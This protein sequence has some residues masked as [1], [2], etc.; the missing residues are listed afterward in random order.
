MY[1][2]E[3]PWPLFPP[4][5]FSRGNRDLELNDLTPFCPFVFE[6]L[7]EHDKPI[8]VAICRGT[9]DILNGERIK[10][11][12]V[13]AP[14][15]L[16]DQYR[17]DPL[18]SSI[19]VDSDLVPK[20]YFADITLNAIA[21]A[22]QGKKQANW[23]VNVHVGKMQ[24]SLFVNGPRHWEYSVLR[25]W[26]LSNA[27]AVEQIPMHYE[28]AF[29]GTWSEAGKVIPF[30]PNPVG[31]GFV[32]AKHLDRTQCIPAPQIEDPANPILELGK[33]YQPA[34]VGP[35]AKHWLPRRALCGTADE[36]WKENRWP[37][38]PRDFDFHYYN[39][40]PPEQVYSG[41]LIGNEDVLVE[42]CSAFGPIH[43]TL[44]SLSVALVAVERNLRIV[45]KQMVLDT[46]HI[47]LVEGK[48]SLTWRSSF[49]KTADLASIY[50]APCTL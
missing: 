22:P 13:Q 18:T 40:A 43:F 17:Q 20:K 32:L 7:D 34:G 37:L 10:I 5:M 46:L 50:L 21:V 3:Y 8:H 39:S 28:F 26:N 38:R 23:T 14:P 4:L 29:G 31:L 33:R 27:E 35:I 19:Q 42:G 47:D 11:C 1:W 6:S 48:C 41:F 24:R 49:E 12:E 25:G 45:P 15:V 44:P 36:K 16:A 2:N 9:F 30:E